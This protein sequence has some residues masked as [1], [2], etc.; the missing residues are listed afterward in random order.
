MVWLC[1]WG[2]PTG[3]KGDRQTGDTGRGQQAGD[4][5]GDRQ[6]GTAGRGTGRQRDMAPVESSHAVLG[7]A[8]APGGGQKSLLRP[9]NAG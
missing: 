3:R 2:E 1:H 5:Q 7:D 8:V 6:Q 4:R 9:G